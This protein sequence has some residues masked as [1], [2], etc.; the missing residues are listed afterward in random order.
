MALHEARFELHRRLPQDADRSDALAALPRGTVVAVF[1]A[2]DDAAAA[3]V[4]LL[5]D[6]PRACLWLR[7]GREASTAIRAARSQ[8]SLA[9]KALRG[10]GNEELRVREVLRH[11]DS[12][13]SVLVMREGKAAAFRTLSLAS[14]IYRFGAWTVQP[15]R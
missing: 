2:R 13:S 3:A 6:D 7:T 1:T 4:E 10:F 5:R 14:H 12:G 15:L 9:M 8:R 11:S